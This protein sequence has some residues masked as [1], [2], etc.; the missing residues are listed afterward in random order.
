MSLLLPAPEN[1]I[2]EPRDNAVRVKWDPV[3]GADGYMLF[4]FKK[5]KPRACIKRRYAQKET[6]QVLGFFN[7]ENYLVAVRAFY[8]E[9]GKEFEGESSEKIPFTPISMDLK[10]QKVLCMTTG[11]IA[12]IDWEYRNTRPYALFYAEDEDIVDV[13]R[14]GIV[15]ALAPG[16]TEIAIVSEGQEIAVKVYVDRGQTMAQAKAVMMFTGDLMCAVNHQRACSSRQF[17]FH[18]SFSPVRKILKEADFTVGVLET[19]CYDPAPYECEQLRLDSGAPNCNSPSSFLTA[20]SEA[21]FDMLVTANNHSCDTGYEGLCATVESI[22]QLGMYNLGALGDNPVFR[23]INGIRVA[24]IAFTMISNKHELNIPE[25]TPDTRAEYSREYFQRMYDLARGGGAEYVVAYQHW[26]SMN[27]KTVKERQIQ[28]SQFMALCGVDLI[29]GSHPHAIQE[30][31]YVTTPRGRKVPCAYSLG[32]FISSQAELNENRDSV[33]LRVEL[34]RAGEEIEADISYIPCISANSPCGVTVHPVDNYFNDATR[35]SLM[36]T[37]E[38]MGADIE[39]FEYR[40]EILLS[41]SV[42]L[43][44]TLDAGNFARVDKYPLLLSQ[45]TACDGEALPT[46]GMTTALE[47]DV[48]KG[49]G[50]Y[51]RNSDADYIAVDFYT[52]A[53]VSCYERNG[54]LYTGTNRFLKSNFYNKRKDEFTRIKP[55]YDEKFWKPLV[56]KYAE[57]VLSEFPSERIILFRYYF[58]DKF[59][60]G[61]TELRNISLRN[62]LNKQIAEMEE[63]FIALTDPSVVNL[64]RHYFT[65]GN[66]PSNYE[67]YYFNDAYG[68]VKKIVRNNRRCVDMPDL[69]IWMERVLNCYENMTARS[70]QS[71]LLDMNNAADVI[72]AYT[73]KEFTAANKSRLLKLKKCGTASLGKISSFFSDDPGAAELI[74]VA[75]LI[76]A[77]LAEDISRPYSFYAPAFEG[78]FNILKKIAKLLSAQTGIYVSSESAERVF[79]LR[80]NPEQLEHYAVQLKNRTADIWGSC[81]SR[82]IFNCCKN[83]GIG[84][85]IFKQC[86]I[87]AYEDPV[88]GQVPEELSQFRNNAW[89]RRTIADAFARTGMEQLKSEHSKWL[90]VDFYDVIC[91]MVDYKGGLFEVDDF[92]KKTGFYKSIEEECEPCCLFDKRTRQQCRD[93]IMRFAFDMLNLYGSNIV[94][95]KADLKDCFINLYKRIEK[96]EDD[97]KLEEKRE[98]IAFCENLFIEQTDCAVIDISKH[99]YASDKFPLGGAHIVHYEHEF[100]REAGV[101]LAHILSGGKQRKF[102]RADDGYISMRN[103]RLERE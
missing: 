12:Q 74:A 3:E 63:Y 80:N 40:P 11:E 99:F 49:F 22:K 61:G 24:F 73:S 66:A 7:G 10:A 50:E 82:E 62:S 16:R 102:T 53:G 72:I 1:V 29:V 48:G 46:N 95:I 39:P 103:L 86:P 97:P 64:A 44:K 25:I 54:T 28:E 69:D 19:T 57:T 71:W 6:K 96:M 42:I 75:K 88:D 51:L 98:F 41:G 9:D 76:R 47:L 56:K 20:V 17:D 58:P 68:A 2:A 34:F 15:R 67:H 32:N 38:I 5:E 18:D 35:K 77:V 8:Y 60:K 13:D 83:S 4:F 27:S 55:P 65:A 89:R 81:I 90:I 70:Y 78:N 101:F 31:R 23:D 26:G 33:I 36:R 30:F 59:V 100:Y 45:L 92:I 79:L 94:L 14:N 85:Y 84:R 52:A 21:G 93:V 43:E 91:D 87:L 37:K